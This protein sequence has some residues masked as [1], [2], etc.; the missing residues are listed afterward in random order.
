MIIRQLDAF[1]AGEAAT[2][3]ESWKDARDR[4]EQAFGPW[5]VR[6]GVRFHLPDGRTVVQF[7]RLI[8]ATPKT[9]WPWLVEP[10]KLKD[11]LG[12]TDVELHVGGAYRIRF[13]MAPIVM[14]GTITEI[15]AQAH[16]LALIWREPWF[17]A[18]DVIL[19]FDLEPDGEGFCRFT[20]THTFPAG[21]DPH[22]YLAGWHEFV[23]ALENAMLGV[24]F[25]WDTPE[26]KR[27]Y[28]LRETVYKAI[29]AAQA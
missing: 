27:E 15:D 23:D 2:P 5:S 22:D 25:V 8:A 6:D 4:L 10:G 20:L 24:A 1:L 26:R 19:A 3:S 12:D 21:Y 28:A 9:V 17:K 18:D 16:H 13:T 14:E 11:W 7:R 29:A